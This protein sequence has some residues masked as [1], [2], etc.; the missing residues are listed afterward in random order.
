MIESSILYVQ[1][2][3][4]SFYMSYVNMTYVILILFQSCLIC[5]YLKKCE[6]EEAPQIP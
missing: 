4:A 3:I 6:L 5:N 1:I 2:N